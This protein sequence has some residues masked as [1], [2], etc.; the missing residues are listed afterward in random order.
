MNPITLDDIDKEWIYDPN[1]LICCIR[2][3]HQAIHYGND[4]YDRTFEIIDRCKND[5][6]PWLTF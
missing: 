3:T 1:Y 6:A 4:E 2:L 5:T